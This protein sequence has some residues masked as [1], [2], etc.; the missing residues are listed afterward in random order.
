MNLF[1]FDELEKNCRLGGLPAAVKMS[2]PSGNSKIWQHMTAGTDDKGRPIA[3]CNYCNKTYTNAPHASTSSKIYHLER[4]HNV[5]FSNNDE[6]PPPAKTP[7][8]QQTSMDSFAVKKKASLEEMVSRLAAE[9]GLTFNQIVTSET[10]RRWIENDGHKA[11]RAHITVER[12]VRQFA[13]ECKE[14]IKREIA[15]ALANGARF[16]STMDEW[17]SKANI[18]YANVNLHWFG[19]HYKLQSWTCADRRG[20]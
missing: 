7:K 9:D 10:I 6:A 20:V 12:M 19:H 3:T 1:C 2:P 17:T 14:A 8:L 5:K 11:P 18:R 4:S 13:Q 15:K 16:S